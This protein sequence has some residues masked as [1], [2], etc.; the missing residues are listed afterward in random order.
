MH[1]V[2]VY[3][4]LLSGMGNHGLL[5][6]SKKIGDTRSPRNFNMIDLGYYPG[7]MQDSH[8]DGVVLGEVYE[9]DDITLA[10]LN[11]LEGYIETDPKRGLYDRIEIDTEFGKA[12]IYIYNDRYGRE[13]SN[14]VEN[15]DWRTY[16]TN[17]FK[18]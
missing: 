14:K 2:F 5:S 9:I 6:T 17:K 16:Y 12:F 18:R 11:R 8:S 3:G 4:S 13:G 15:G 10:R 7:V 1:K